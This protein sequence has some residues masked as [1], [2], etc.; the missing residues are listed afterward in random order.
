MAAASAALRLKAPAPPDPATIRGTSLGSSAGAISAT[1]PC[2]GLVNADSS[3]YAAS[4]IEPASEEGA[5]VYVCMHV[6]VYVCLCVC[7]YVCVRV[8]M[9]LEEGEV[10]GVV[11]ACMSEGK[12]QCM[13]LLLL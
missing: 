6:C 7:V 10:E 5:C 2:A 1:S 12:L 4:D 3:P 13:L 8:R 9:C 11:D